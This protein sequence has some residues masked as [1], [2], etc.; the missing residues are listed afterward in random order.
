MPLFQRWRSANRPVS[1]RATI[2]TSAVLL[3]L[4]LVAGS[5]SILRAN[6]TSTVL[7]AERSSFPAGG[8][9]YIETHH[10]GGR[11]FNSYGLGG[12]AIWN[13]NAAFPVFID[14]RADTVYTGQVLQD[15]LTIYNAQPG[16]A[17]LL[18]QYRIQWLFVEPSAPIAVVL[19][20]RP[21]WRMMF[22]GDL[23][24]IIDYKG[25]G[26]WTK[27]LSWIVQRTEIWQRTGI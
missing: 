12:Y 7:A 23:S 25:G 17:R 21:G 11:V 5:L 19:A 2:P 20:Q 22:H 4:M 6:S 9:A 18:Q 14:S 24:T 13:T 8:M 3:L 16:W 15:Y 26:K 1:S 10:L 27:E